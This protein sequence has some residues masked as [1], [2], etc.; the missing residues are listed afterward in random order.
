MVAT[1]SPAPTALSQLLGVPVTFLP[2]L[3]NT[4]STPTLNVNSLGAETITKGSGTVLSVGDL[5][6]TVIAE[7]IW[8]GTNF[9]LQNP[10]VGIVQT[11][12]GQGGTSFA[13]G[14]LKTNSIVSNN[15]ATSS[16]EY[17]AAQNLSSSSASNLGAAILYGPTNTSTG[18]AGNAS[19]Q[20]GANT[21]TGQQG[22][23]NVIQSFTIAAATTIGYVMQ[24]TTT[25]DR[26]VAAALGSTNNLGVATTVGG[27][28][29]Q[30][31]VASEGK[32]LVVFDG[33]PV[34]GDYA[35]APPAATGTIG[36]AHDNALVAC[37]A[38][39]NL[40][41]IT[42]QVSGTGSGATATVLLYLG[43]P[44]GPTGTA[45]GVLSGT[46][47]NPGYAVTPVTPATLNGGTLPVSAT[48]ITVSGTVS[49]T[50]SGAGVLTLDG[51]TSGTATITAPSI[52]GTATNPVVFS[53]WI[54]APGVL[55]YGN[56]VS[57]SP[58]VVTAEGANISGAALFTAPAIGYYQICA[59]ET[60]TRA[61]STSSV[62]PGLQVTYYDPVDSNFKIINLLGSNT[63][64]TTYTANT[65]C[66][67][68]NVN[69]TAITY[70][71]I[72][73]TTVGATSMQYDLKIT[74]LSEN[75]SG[76]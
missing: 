24:M 10:Q 41:I 60:I 75:A 4:T 52:A 37:P 61:A 17:S 13:S 71:T 9:V 18:A 23:A 74:V 58:V 70:S 22:F 53:N 47:P 43:I 46:Y 35:C 50:A 36:L 8:N 39:Q 66:A 42:G 11:T 27:T 1:L 21:S 32:V 2:N 51:A 49:S 68:V 73:Y 59:E 64:N 31:W 40:G 19:V 5:A 72:N 34:V 3:A 55:T 16:V 69:T 20:A 67:I 30:L 28:A 25:T 48:T 54:S 63:G 45:G 44:T 7:V 29:A 38:G 62:M 76:I 12:G 15:S 57:V 33:T 56:P 65:G 14:Q 6:T 26:V